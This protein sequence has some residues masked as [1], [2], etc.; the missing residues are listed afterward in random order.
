M[1]KIALKA[2]V[3]GLTS[4]GVVVMPFM[5]IWG[6]SDATSLLENIALR[7]FVFL[8]SIPGSL[9]LTFTFGAVLS[10][11]LFIVG[12]LV[13][14][15]LKE[16]IVRHPFLFSGLAPLITIGLVATW[17]AVSRDNEWAHT[18]GFLEKFWMLVIS[19]DIMVYAVPVGFASGYFCY[20]LR[21]PNEPSQ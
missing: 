10:A 3:V 11:P 18:H 15:T 17:T 1:F 7:A 21:K 2:W 8:A 9:F 12:Y 20:R 19:W 16:K 6:R 13:A 14:L 5:Q 4:A